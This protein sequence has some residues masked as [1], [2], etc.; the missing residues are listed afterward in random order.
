MKLHGHSHTYDSELDLCTTCGCG[1][2]LLLTFCPGV[3]LSNSARSAISQGKV[4]DM[5]NAGLMLRTRRE[6][7]IR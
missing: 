7:L 5:A 2:R 6:G 3:R 1:G 4:I